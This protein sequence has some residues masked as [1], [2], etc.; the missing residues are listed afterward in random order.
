[1]ASRPSRGSEVDMSRMELKGAKKEETVKEAI[2]KDIIFDILLS[3]PPNTLIRSDFSRSHLAIGNHQNLVALLDNFEFIN[4]DGSQGE[5]AIQPDFDLDDIEVCSCNGLL[6]LLFKNGT[7]ALWNPAIREYKYCI[8]GAY[9]RFKFTVAGTTWEIYSLRS[10]SW[11]HMPTLPWNFMMLS[12]QVGFFVDGNLHW[13]VPYVKAYE[14][15]EEGFEF[16][17]GNLMEYIL[18][19]N[20]IHCDSQ[21]T[22]LPFSFSLFNLPADIRNTHPVFELGVF[23]GCIC[24]VHYHAKGRKPELN[25]VEDHTIDIWT[26]ELDAA[27]EKT[28]WTKLITIPKLYDLPPGQ[29]APV[30][31]INNGELLLNVTVKRGNKLYLFNP[32]EKLCSVRDFDNKTRYFHKVITYA[33][34]L[35]SPNAIT[36]T[37]EE[38]SE[39][40]YIVAV[41]C[42]RYKNS[43]VGFAYEYSSSLY[44]EVP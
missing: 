19:M 34:T 32:E 44:T 33:E 15:S 7:F 27:E 23:K 4:P 39:D 17:V 21:N 8:T 29:Y 3:L 30:C 2:P 24:L 36:I 20:L 12:R 41:F 9:T 37:G 35:L 31:T 26:P 25:K 14:S 1:M 38:D 13:K 28:N 11:K 42:Y 10:N 6:C 5:L 22:N 18:I 43:S 16:D 40:E